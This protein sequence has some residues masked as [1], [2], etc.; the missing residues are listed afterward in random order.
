M[1]V[2]DAARA[3]GVSADYIR[4]L[5]RRGVL[6]I[7]RDRNG[8]RRLTPEV[9]AALRAAIFPDLPQHDGAAE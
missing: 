4:R 2:I 5:D 3:L 8:H 6:R 9:F 1:R 7:P